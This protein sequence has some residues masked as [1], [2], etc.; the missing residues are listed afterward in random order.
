MSDSEVP[1][2]EDTEPIELDVPKYEDT[3]EIVDGISKV[4][5]AI[6]GGRHGVSMGTSDEIGGLVGAGLD[7]TQQLLNAL[8]LADKSPSQVNT[9]LAKQGVTGDVGPEDLLSTYRQYRDEE[10]SKMDAAQRTNPGSFLGGSIAGGLASTLFVPGAISAPLG[11]AAKNASLLT[12]VGTGAAN[13]LPMGLIAGLGAGESDLTDGDVSGAV[14]DTLIGGA[15]AAGTG[16]AIPLVSAGAKGAIPLVGAGAKG[17]KNLIGKIIPDEVKGAYELGKQGIN[18]VGQEFYDATTG[19]VRSIVDKV[20][21]VLGKKVKGQHDLLADEVAKKEATS[22]KEIASLDNQILNV[23]KDVK[24]AVSR[25]QE[26]AAVQSSKDIVQ[27]QKNELAIAEKVQS[28]IAQLRKRLGKNYDRIDKAAEKLDIV[29]DSNGVVKN[30]ID[31]ITMNSEMG[32]QKVASL[33]KEMLNYADAKT[34]QATQQLKDRLTKL[35]NHENRAVSSAAKKAYADL[36]NSYLQAFNDAGYDSLANKLVENNKR[37]ST[38]AKLED[39]YFSNVR[40][41]GEIADRD[42]LSTVAK[43]GGKDS[44][45]VADANEVSQL[46]GILDPKQAPGLVKSMSRVADEGLELSGPS[47]MKR[48]G[49]VD[50][51]MQELILPNPELSRLENLSA[52]VKEAAKMNAATPEQLKLASSI[53]GLPLNVSDPDALNRQLTNLLPKY[54]TKSGDNVAENQLQDLFK[55][56]AKD[57]GDDFVNATKSEIAS[58]NKDLAIRDVINAPKN[59]NFTRAGLSGAVGTTVGGPVVGATAGAAS[60]LADKILGGATGLANKAGLATSDSKLLLQNGIKYLSDASPE[61]L[62][63]F[64]QRLAGVGKQGAE[65]ALVLAQA[66]DKNSQSRNAIIFGLMQQPTFRDL[67]RQ[68]NEQE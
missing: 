7:K 45:Q 67:I 24:S 23:E 20:S 33:T 54:G 62:K 40:K 50:D 27:Q 32:D 36:R 43:F 49:L 17:A 39:N 5:S 37:W 13:A 68:I 19:K 8:G 34:P 16:G 42:S 26:R 21:D 52:Q 47:G 31:D 2:F 55:T 51:K 46:L 30:L 11:Q 10:R 64:S 1:K 28:R 60:G 3:E 61:A 44:K 58:A 38:A 59:L 57:Q 15:L 25:G 22:A 53:E 35:F 4:D 65:Y 41:I 14:G 66:A 6:E 48:L 63:T 29:P 9:E 12:K 18:V 56:L